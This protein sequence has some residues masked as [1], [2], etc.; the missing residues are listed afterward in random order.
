MCIGWFVL[1]QNLRK[2]HSNVLFITIMKEFSVMSFGIYL[3]HIFIMRRWI[4][5]WMPVGELPLWLE[6]VTVALS[7]FILSYLLVKFISKFP[8]SKYVIG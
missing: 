8:F 6:I 2:L 4:W 1:V 5:T 7:T 3:I